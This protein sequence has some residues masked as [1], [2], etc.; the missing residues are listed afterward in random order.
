MTTA[1]PDIAAF[2]RPP[3]L[4]KGQRVALVSP[5]GPSSPERIELSIQ[6]CRALGLEPVPGR[7]AAARTGYLAG[8][9]ASRVA[10]LQRAIEDDS[11]DAVWAIRGGYGV[12]RLLGSLELA[13]LHRRPKAILGFSDNTALHLALA[14]ERIISF[15]AP[16]AGASEF[17]PFTEH[18]F[19]S[20]MF[21]EWPP[22]LEPSTEARAIRPGTADGILAGGNLSLLA[23]C[24]GTPWQLEGCG[25]I[26]L[27]EDIN[28]PAYR[29]DRALTQLRLAGCLDGAA[30]IGF[31][32][33]TL[34]G[35][36]A[37]EPEIDEVLRERTDGLGIPVVAGLPF[38][39]IDEQ[40]TIPLGARARL[41][42][43]T[44][45]LEIE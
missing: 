10:D 20:V 40:W 42:A 21:D 9:D 17:P 26:V 27:I 44:G 3:A 2:E 16:H 11:I 34:T 29:V 32:S 19:R 22:R 8:D 5:A 13:P 1:L 31:G 35:A 38:G 18:S 37:P 6:R 23:A 15:H 43:A 39:H 12:M 14:R 28:E 24:C 33:F 25:R 41:D 4:R 36:A 30:A 7:S 45:V